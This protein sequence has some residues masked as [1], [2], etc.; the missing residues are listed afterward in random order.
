M[1]ID[2]LQKILDAE[3]L[4]PDMLHMALV[5]LV[6]GG[7][8]KMH[9]LRRLASEFLQIDF[10]GI[11]GAVHLTAVMD[12]ILHLHIQDQRLVGILDM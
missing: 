10:K 7:I 12:E 8:D 2:A 9:Q 1:G 3:S 4:A 6:N 5:F 11:V